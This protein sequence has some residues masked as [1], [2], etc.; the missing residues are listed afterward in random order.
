MKSNHNNGFTLVEVL[1]TVVILAIGL[2]GLAGLQLNGL[3]HNTTAYER[4]Q[5]I[6]LAYDIIDR[7]RANRDNVASY[8]TALN[9]EPTSTNCFGA[10]ADCSPAEIAAF[11][12]NQW[13]CSLGQWVDDADCIA[14]DGAGIIDSTGKLSNGDGSISINAVNETVTVTIQWEENRDDDAN[15]FTSLSVTTLI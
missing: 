8:A 11:D 15:R 12:L 5:A 10:A 4:S 7:M 14:L 13:K 1:V 6:I 9:V 3:L 2:L